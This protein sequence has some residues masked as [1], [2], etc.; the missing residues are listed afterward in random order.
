MVAIGNGLT[1]LN[2]PNAKTRNDASKAGDSSN[3]NTFKATVAKNLSTASKAT[4]ST[5]RNIIY[6]SRDFGIG[7]QRSIFG[8][9]K[10]W[11]AK[12]Y[13][14]ES[15]KLTRNTLNYQSGR[16][17]ETEEAK[18]A[19]L[20]N[21]SHASCGN[22]ATSNDPLSMLMLANAFAT[23][24]AKAKS[25]NKTSSNDGAGGADKSSNTTNTT[26]TSSNS[27]STKSLGEMK[28][29]KSSSTLDA[30]LQKAKADQSAMPGKIDSAETELSTLKGE[31]DK[32]RSK[33]EGAQKDLTKNEEDIKAQ[34][35]KVNEA[36]NAYTAC[37]NTYDAAMK[38]PDEVKDSKGN[39]I[40]DNRTKKANAKAA[41]EKAEADLKAAK[42]ELAKL[43]EATKGLKQAVGDAKDAYDKNIESIKTKQDEVAQLKADQKELN[44]EIPKQQKRLEKLQKQE[45]DELSK[46]DNKITDLASKASNLL[47][48]I[49]VN[50]ENGLSS[51]D[52]KNKEQ[53]EK[54]NAEAEKQ[55][56][57]KIELEN[58][59]A[60]RKTQ[61]TW[62]G[63]SQFKTAKN[64][65][66]EDVYAIDGNL[67]N[68]D[69]YNRKKTEL[70]NQKS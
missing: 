64:A 27:N 41:L 38:L 7:A 2:I 69:E 52:I 40:A 21:M 9:G 46:I 57:R 12:E 62:I 32:L 5:S 51:K 53:A 61:G 14:S 28:N 35:G 10:A 36:Q 13:N 34:S 6:T 33:Y 68:K 23:Q 22:Q 45:D 39:V 60:I 30:A 29:A 66:G 26:S 31:T 67:V 63:G 58:K 47:K 56:A 17:R 44:S 24:M 25:A 70:G 1:K 19:R 50:D 65:K 48:G 59:A 15:I 4:G 3:A 16:L 49:D 43:Q 42:E 8:S 18:Y 37:K 20:Y 54:L 11:N 55:K